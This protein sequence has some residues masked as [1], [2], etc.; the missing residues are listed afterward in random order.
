MLR[1]IFGL[2]VA[3]V[4]AEAEAQSAFAPPMVAVVYV[5][6]ANEAQ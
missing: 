1:V 5:G 3:P 6:G 4:R 2:G